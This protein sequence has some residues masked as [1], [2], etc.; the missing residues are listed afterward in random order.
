MSAF[1]SPLERMLTFFLWTLSLP[2]LQGEVATRLRVQVASSFHRALLPC[3][4][5]EEPILRVSLQDDWAALPSVAEVSDSSNE[6]SMSWFLMK[7]FNMLYLIS[8]LVFAIYH[9]EM[10][11]ANHPLCYFPPPNRA[12]VILPALWWGLTLLSRRRRLQRVRC[13]FHWPDALSP[14]GSA[15]LLLPWVLSHCLVLSCFHGFS[16][17]LLTTNTRSFLKSKTFMFPLDSLNFSRFL[18]NKLFQKCW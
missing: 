1:F 8:T 15:T 16:S 12:L 2:L 18:S 14:F 5:W 3:S 7:I 6:I 11:G 4:L 17:L 9:S 13:L 10:W